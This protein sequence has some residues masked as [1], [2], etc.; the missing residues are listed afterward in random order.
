MLII[1]P[2]GRLGNNIAQILK[3][4]SYSLSLEKPIKISLIE[5]KN[6]HPKFL[7]NL[8]EYLFNYDDNKNILN[9]FWKY[10]EYTNLE[11]QEKSITMLKPFF[12]YN[13]NI[14]DSIDFQNTLIIHFRG[15]DSMKGNHLINFK[16]PPYYFYKK[17]IEENIFENILLVIEDRSNPIIQKLVDNYKNIKI[18]SNNQYEDFKIIMNA[19]YFVNSSSS[20][21]SSAI[22]F[23]NN[24]KKFYTSDG[25]HNYRKNFN[26]VNVIKYDLTNYYNKKFENGKE[27]LDFLLLEKDPFLI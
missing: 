27:M 9:N 25:M 6:K 22:L 14:N 20:F 2:F 3:C 4:L 23:N 11:L 19:H 17:I 18:T 7:N 12:N 16:H 5:L 15:G 1:H 21:S 8:P 26:N 13:L 10:N 24:L